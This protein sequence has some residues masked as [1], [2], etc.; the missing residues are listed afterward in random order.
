MRRLLIGLFIV[1]S[2][3]TLMLPTDAIHREN[4]KSQVT[5]IECFNQNLVEAVIPMQPQFDYYSK[6]KGLRLL[7][8]LSNLTLKDVE[9]INSLALMEGYSMHKETNERVHEM[10]TGK[11]KSLGFMNWQ[12]FVKGGEHNRTYIFTRDFLLQKGND[13]IGNLDET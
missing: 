10:I 9:G 13:N 6:K 11:M 2:V 3:K 8:A 12:A 7:S 5:L 1:L 4:Y